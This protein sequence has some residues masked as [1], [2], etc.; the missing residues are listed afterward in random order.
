[1][2]WQIDW[3]GKSSVGYC[4]LGQGNLDS[5]DVPVAKE[6]LVFMATGNNTS[7]KL[8]LGYCLID[9]ISRDLKVNLINQYLIKLHETG[10]Q[11]VA[12][13]CIPGVGC[14]N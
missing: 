7:W 1:M 5:D 13:T 6:A 11:C 12:L 10:V 8:P 14:S 2:K 9:G 3:D 4:D